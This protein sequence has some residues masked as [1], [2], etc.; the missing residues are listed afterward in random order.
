[1]FTA[2]I[3]NPEVTAAGIYNLLVTAPNG[4]EATG[5]IIITADEEVPVLTIL[6]D[7]LGCAPDT[8]MIQ[9]FSS[10]AGSTFSWT[11][12]NG[13]IS[14]S[15]NPE[16][17]L[18]GLYNLTVS[19]PNGCISVNSFEVIADVEVPTVIAIGDTIDCTNDVRQLQG[20]SN[21]PGADYYWQ[22]P[23]GF[24]SFEE[25]PLVD[26]TGSYNLSVTGPNGC[27]G[28]AVADL[29]D[30]SD[31]VI[32]LATIGGSLDCEITSISIDG[33]SSTIGSSINYS[34]LD[35]NNNII[36]NT[37]NI[38]VNAVGVYTLIVNDINTSC[39]DTIQ[40][41][42]A[43]DTITPSAI[44][45][46]VGEQSITCDNASLILS[47]D[48]SSPAANISFEWFFNG[49]SFSN[50]SEVEVETAGEYLVEIINLL[51]GC[52]D[53]ASF[54]VAADLEYPIAV[55]SAD[56]ELDC[57]N[58][59][60]SLDGTGSS[61]GN[62]FEYLWT[63]GNI[64]SGVETLNPTVDQIGTYT[65]VVLNSQNGCSSEA[66]VEVGGSDDFIEGVEIVA[67]EPSCFEENDGSIIIGTIIGGTTPYVYKIDNVITTF[68]T[69]EN[70]S[71]G[72]YQLK[73]LDGAGC[74][75]DTVIMLN[76][77]IQVLLNLGEDQLISLGDSFLLAPVSTIP[78][79]QLDTFYWTQEELMPCMNCF[80]QWVMPFETTPYELTVI[81][82]NGC[83]AI[84][85]ILI[86]VKKDRVVFIP[87]IFTPDNDGNN[88][89]FMIYGGQDVAKVKTFVIFDRWGETLFKKD[90]FIPNDPVSGWDGTLKG[91]PLNPAVF[92]YFAEIEFIDG[93]VALFKGDF[94]L[95]RN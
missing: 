39:F 16:V 63:G 80:E 19:G 91:R 5:L 84:D 30:L 83:I 42:V 79:L 31:N 28:I 46:V 56:E 70:L 32:A 61:A 95:I 54:S 53:S 10:V 67:T 78:F 73:I 40:I 50:L 22:G 72:S 2:T 62:L 82:Q 77:P 59:S 55:A 3:S 57:F 23:N 21:I 33:S 52:V 8:I 44:I 43:G 34:W 25:N 81:N 12:P 29:L 76:Q 89:V 13:F 94:T 37:V 15:S 85:D 20:M 75:F 66:E 58:Q 47:T 35:F 9:S 87:N 17:T 69:F 48:G 86:R 18:V 92:V 38:N 68:G 51:N 88:D 93:R 11:G 71:A 45:N 65:L 36:G 27:T 14:V 26:L 64:L 74:E 6:G 49:N 1:G 24:E 4:C 60:L 90:N 7:T 41:A